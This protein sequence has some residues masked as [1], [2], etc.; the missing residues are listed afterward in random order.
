MSDRQLHLT[1]NFNH[2]AL[3]DVEALGLPQPDRFVINHSA[4]LD[5]FGVLDRR[6]S[7]IDA[8]ASLANIRFLR[9]HHAFSIERREVG[10]NKD[11]EPITILV[12]KDKDEKFDVHRWDFSVDLYN[13]TGIGRVA[14]NSVISYSVQDPRT[15]IW[16]ARPD[17]VLATKVGTNRENDERDLHHAAQL[18]GLKPL[19]LAV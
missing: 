5:I 8:A 11:G 9:E 18:Y 13:K 10:S 6:Y 1:P 17:Y 15:G 12:S 16:V 19:D 7:D 14:L 3:A 4:A 2:Q